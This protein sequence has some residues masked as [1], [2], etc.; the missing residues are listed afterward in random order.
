M[1]CL[2]AGV[3]TQNCPLFTSLRILA[4]YGYGSQR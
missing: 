2:R 3:R 4:G 1:S